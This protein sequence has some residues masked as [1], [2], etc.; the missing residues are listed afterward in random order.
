MPNNKNININKYLEYARDLAIEKF[1]QKVYSV[2]PLG[3]E[4]FNLVPEYSK[5]EFKVFLKDYEELYLNL[6]L[7]GKKI[8]GYD[9]V[10][11]D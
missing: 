9:F 4:T 11:K 10:Y 5:I 6:F 7:K 2:I 3:I 8:T 1:G